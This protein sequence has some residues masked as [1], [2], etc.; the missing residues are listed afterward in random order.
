MEGETAMLTP[1]FSFDEIMAPIGVE[2][3]LA[4]Y[5]DQQPLHLEGAAD[6][7]AQVMSWAKLDQLLDQSSIWSPETL[8]LV[9]D[10][11]PVPTRDY[12]AAARNREGV[13]AM[14]PQPGAVQELIRRGATVVANDIQDLNPGLSAVSAALRETLGAKI[15]ANLYMSSRRRRAFRSHCD[16]HDVYAV[17]VEGTKTWNVYEGRAQAPIHHRRFKAS[18]RIDPDQAKGRLMMAVHMTPGDLLY[19]PRGWYHDALADDGGTIHVAFGAVHMVGLDVITF[20]FDHML[21]EPGVRT[22]L[23]RPRTD[24]GGALAAHLARLGDRV[25]E[26]LREPDTVARVRALQLGDATPRPSYDVLGLLTATAGQCF[27]VRGDDVRLVGQAG[28][29][30]LL[31]EGSR[32]AIEVPAEVSDM[33]GWVLKRREFT[34]VELARAFPERQAADLDALLRDLGTMRLTEPL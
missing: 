10:S 11:E 24:D 5:E 30:G 18:H 25:A 2:R 3:F 13:Q 1:P 32:N 23:P 8:Q 12:C 31:K 9:V 6:K 21:G 20:L 17:Q 22:N 28:R 14:I 19:L 33:V 34:R 15:Q 26:V 29:F 27:R 7:F 4:E 16:A